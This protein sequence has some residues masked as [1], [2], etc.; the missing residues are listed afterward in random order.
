MTLTAAQR[1]TVAILAFEP[2][3]VFE[4]AVGCEVFG[5][6]RSYHGVPNYRLL[7]CGVQRGTI[8]TGGGFS[9]NLEHG[10]EALDE[11]G[12]VIVPAYP[13]AAVDTPPEIALEALRR[14]NRRGARIASLCSGA[15]VL[16]AAGLLDGK[17]AT[18]HWLYAE[19]LA[20]DYPQIEVDPRVL[21]VDE[22]L[23][24]TSAGT[25][26]GIDLCLHMVRLDH[27]A[28][29]ANVY[30]RRM[31]VPPHRDGGQAQYVA[32]PVPACSDED[33]L[34]GT[35]AWAI[36]HLDE[37]LTV[38]RLA[39]VAHE[40][41]RTFA[42]R[43]RDAT[44]TTPL[45]WVIAQRIVLAQRLLETTDLG[46]DQIAARCGFGS[47]PAFRVHFSRKLGTSPQAYRRQFRHGMAAAS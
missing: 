11:A 16:A 25:A 8:A 29:V 4:L 2:V 46:V 42:R 36:E 38:K 30:A 6:D 37:D 45:Q 26:A 33:P 47:G 3:S 28:D 14:A 19:R 39:E 5:I 9:I 44:G 24:L 21:Y 10:L 43:F 1:E 32:A 35:L 27:G 12:T 22:G 34:A 17:R 40:S 15:F 18:T 41:S 23:V 7:V 31:V 20:R 13:T